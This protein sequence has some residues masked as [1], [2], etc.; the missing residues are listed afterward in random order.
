MKAFLWRVLALTAVLPLL[1]ACAGSPS[2]GGSSVTLPSSG[3][4]GASSRESA[5]VSGTTTSAAQESSE[6]VTSAASSAFSS[7]SASSGASSAASS[8]ASSAA[9]S[10]ASSA[11]SSKAS[12]LASSQATSSAFVMPG[13]TRVING[14]TY[15]LTFKDDF[16]GDKLDTS[17]WDY[18]PDWDRGD[19]AVPAHWYSDMVSVKDGAL[20]LSAEEGSNGKIRCGAVRT[21]KKNYSKMLFSQCKG[22]FECRAKLPTSKGCIG[23]F[24]LM[25]RAMGNNDVGNGA[26]DGAEIDIMESLAYYNQVNHA[27]HWDGYGSDHKSV[28]NRTT[29]SALFNGFHTYGLAWSEEAYVW[30]VDGREVWRT[31]T[32][33]CNQNPMYLKLTV[34]FGEWAGIPK[35]PFARDE[36]VVDYVRVWQ[37]E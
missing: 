5:A 25:D 27:L 15:T 14:K 20:I 10:R 34:E 24:W 3:A 32:P 12:S 28:D 17:K 22:Y 26:R 30:Y 31:S 18:G 2:G 7:G 8:R 13:D 6:A 11:V 29:D 16:D 19:S 23:A 36:F 1:S 21:L 35:R 9:S 37:A 33:G 4:G